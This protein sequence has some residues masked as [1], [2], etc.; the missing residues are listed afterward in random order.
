MITGM[1]NGNLIR[2]ILPAKVYLTVLQELEEFDDYLKN[3]IRSFLCVDDVS[4]KEDSKPIF[5]EKTLGGKSEKSD[6][7]YGMILIRFIKR[8]IRKKFSDLNYKDYEITLPYCKEG[9]YIESNYKS[10][11]PSEIESYKQIKAIVEKAWL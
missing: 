6:L 4:V 5:F 8:I 3:G 11:S 2:I 7:V 1:D 10:I 9:Y